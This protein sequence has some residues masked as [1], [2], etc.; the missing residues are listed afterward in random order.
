[1]DKS[2]I[3]IFMAS[4]NH[5]KYIRTTIQS[6]LDQTFEDFVFYIYDDGST[7]DSWEIIKSFKDPRI[8]STRKNVNTNT[9]DEK[10]VEKTLTDYV[11]MLHSDDFWEPTKLEKQVRFLDEHPDVGAVFTHVN[12]I[13]EDGRPLTNKS[14][15]YYKVFDQPNRTRHEW[16]NFF[17]YNRNALCHPS[18]L[19]RQ[20]CYQE[21]DYY[22]QS[23]RQL[24]DLDL[25]VRLCFK[26]DIHILQERLTNFRVR[27]GGRNTSADRPETHTRTE[28]E[29]LQIL[30]HYKGLTDE[31]EFIK[32]F[33]QAGKYFKAE[34]SDIVFALAMTALEDQTTNVSKLFGI[35]L[36]FDLFKD[37]NRV[38]S[39]KK[40][41]G[42]SLRD[43]HE[44]TGRYDI[45]STIPQELIFKVK[46]LLRFRVIRWLVGVFSR[47]KNFSSSLKR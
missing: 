35:N 11:A 14:D 16:L 26:Y 36:L 34:G 32:V 38:E 6:V 8:N 9:I 37:S 27:A 21:L 45:F 19:I 42:F 31:S 3:N 40:L 46:T 44:I 13:G 23:F 41:Y 25:W 28:I 18:L 24:P 33:P 5:G 20:S 15:S 22:N 43:F 10:I 12:V 17:F 4:Y 7:D 29:F 1:M 30:E 2:R 39:I 47:N